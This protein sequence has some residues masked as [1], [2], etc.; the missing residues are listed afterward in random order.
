MKKTGTEQFIPKIKEG[1]IKTMKE[2]YN[3]KKEESE[4]I[5]ESF[6]TVIEDASSYLFSLNHSLPYSYIGYICG[7]L[8]YY[9]PL[10][11]ITTTLNINKDDADK[12]NKTIEYAKKHN[13]TF[14][15]PRFRYSKA[16]YFMDKENNAIYKGIASIKYMNEII[17]NEMY[18][19]RD[20]KYNN[21][22]ELLID[23][24]EKTSLNS[25][26]LNILISSN[27]F[28]EFG[29]S[30]KLFDIVDLYN[31]IM[32]KKLKSK[33]G[34]VSFNKNNPPY[35]KEIIEKYATEKSK[36]E[37][38]KQYKVEN[39]EG[40][41]NEL[42]E[43][44]LDMEMSSIKKVRINLEMM[45][46]CSYHFEDYANSICV[47]LDV[48][49]KYKTKKAKLFNIASGK[50]ADIKIGEGDFGLLPFKSLDVIEIYSLVKKPKKVEII[51][52]GK[53]KWRN[54]ETEAEFWLTEYIVLDDSEIEELDKM[55]REYRIANM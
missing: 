41:C 4:Q 45:G 52:D 19:L 31:N 20:N 2:K 44:I 11:F 14:K 29:K 47:V 26:Q 51:V 5:V 55:E 50:I 9:Y 54:S 7:Y 1:F 21:F 17:A 48:D 24:Q 28:D 3:V 10:E 38:Y 25:R 36:E 6:I 30:Q 27:F 12:T 8:R 49:T 15:Q 16:E 22:M 35:P 23:L 42:M 37:R 18:E 43:N 53:K 40:L 46:E 39:V 34:E 33:K 13:I 32:A